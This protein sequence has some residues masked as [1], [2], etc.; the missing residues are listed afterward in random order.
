VRSRLKLNITELLSAEEE[1]KPP[2]RHSACKSCSAA[3]GHVN[4]D[5][6]DLYF[7]DRVVCYLCRLYLVQLPLHFSIPDF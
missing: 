3:G 4:K 7:L 2:F 5:L 1:R 6:Q